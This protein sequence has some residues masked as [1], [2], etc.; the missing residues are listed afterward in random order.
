MKL[1]SRLRAVVRGALFPF[2][3]VPSDG[4][5]LSTPEKVREPYRESVWVAA[6]IR[7]I[8]KPISAVDLQFTRSGGAGALVSD[9][10]LAAYWMTPARGMTGYAEFLLA[11]IGW[12]KLAGECFWVLDDSS[13]VPF[14]E[15][16][17]RFPQLILVRPDRMRHVVHDDRLEGWE[18]TDGSRRRHVLLPEQVIHLKQWNPYDDWRG[19]GE[20]EAARVAVDADAASGRFQRNLAQSNGDQGVYVVAKGGIPDDAQRTQIVAQLREKRSL[21]QRGIFKPVFLGGD[22]TVEDPKVRTVD[23]AF[24]EGRRMNAEEI[25]VAFG[26]PPSM[27][28]K[29]ES[30][31]IGSASDYFR[32][33]LDTCQP[34][35]AALAGGIA[36]VS[37]RLVGRTD[38]WA[39]F[40]WSRHPVMQ[41]VRR[42][43]IDALGKLCDRGMPVADAG[44]YLDLG[45]PRFEGDEI[46]YLPMSVIPA[47]EAATPD[48]QPQYQE[49]DDTESGDPVA[50]ALRVLR[51]APAARAP[52]RVALW[53]EH[54]RKRQGAVTSYR[55]AFTRELFRART[56]VLRKLDRHATAGRSAPATRAGAIDFLFDLGEFTQALQVSFRGVGMVALNTAGKQLFAEIGAD[57]PFTF[58]PARAIQ[59]LHERENR[60]ADVANDV[61]ERVKA[62]LQD[63]LNAG[64]GMPALATLVRGEFNEISR[65]RAL[66][67]AMT[68]TA[69]AYGVARQEA[70][71]QAG[72]EYKQ[73]LTSGGDNVRPAH[74]HA[75]GQIVR[76]DEPFKVGDEELMYPGDPR[77]SAANVINCHCVAIAVEGKEP[78]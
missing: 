20:L 44:R 27:A 61:F 14:P 33:I 36:L 64:D 78:S 15:V 55:R 73:W 29:M 39:G 25:Y 46:G 18:Y 35:A 48:S 17:E 47:T 11:S 67:I 65:E 12:R 76:S 74:A 51:A 53:R 66:R 72:I 68:E 10:R 38:L 71:D 31:S 34:E 50:E 75:G 54:M 26:V 42:E 59:F 30:Y 23:A 32:L 69:A 9:P 57:D 56:D 3:Q 49:T 22:I 52:R 13:V 41:A 63:G 5:G 45:L 21:Q 77:G 28:S 40:D 7:H 6:A 62:V 24:L 70:M 8:A 37:Q 19:L 43:S 1:F 16:R 60:L 4:A 2:N 58:P